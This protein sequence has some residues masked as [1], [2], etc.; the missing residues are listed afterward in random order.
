MGVYHS[1]VRVKTPTRPKLKK[2]VDMESDRQ[3]VDVRIL[4]IVDSAVLKVV[5]EFKRRIRD[6][7]LE[8]DEEVLLEIEGKEDDDEDDEDEEDP[9]E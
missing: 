4:S 8:C 7:F 3:S 2:L 5:E 6:G 1:S 9:E